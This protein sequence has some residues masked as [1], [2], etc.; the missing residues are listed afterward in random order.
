MFT[1]VNLCCRSMLVELEFVYHFLHLISELRYYS[2]PISESVEY[3]DYGY[4]STSVR[5]V[6]NSDLHFLV[7][8]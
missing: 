8:N 3:L 7:L 2:L 1:S 4:S 6:V 5:L